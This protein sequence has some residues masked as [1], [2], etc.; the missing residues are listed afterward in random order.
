MLSIEHCT[1]ARASADVRDQRLLG[2]IALLSEYESADV[3][4]FFGALHHTETNDPENNGHPKQTIRDKSVPF[5]RS[6]LALDQC[7]CTYDGRPT[8]IT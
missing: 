4:I 1:V 2:E 6:L 8:H 5:E 3:Q 7:W